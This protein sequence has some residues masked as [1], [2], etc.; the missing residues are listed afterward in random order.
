MHLVRGWGHGEHAGAKLRVGDQHSQA[1]DLGRASGQR[2]HVKP[3][4]CFECRRTGTMC[5]NSTCSLNISTCHATP[6]RLMLL[7]PGILHEHQCL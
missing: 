4:T 7:V 2:P 1:A 5:V 6:L 3:A